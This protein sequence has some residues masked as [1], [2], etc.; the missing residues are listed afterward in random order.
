MET[1]IPV[2]ESVQVVAFEVGADSWLFSKS[3]DL[4]IDP[5]ILSS[6]F[7]EP[8]KEVPPNLGTPSS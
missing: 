6:L 4:N 5:Q 3:G 1:T 2:S 8:P 7:Q